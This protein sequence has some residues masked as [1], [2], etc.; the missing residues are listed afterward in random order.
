MNRAFA[1]ALLLLSSPVARGQA[2]V[3]TPTTNFSVGNALTSGLYGSIYN[4]NAIAGTYSVPNLLDPTMGF[5]TTQVG[6]Y[7]ANTS[8]GISYGTPNSADNQVL[9]TWLQGDGASVVYTAPHIVPVFDS[10]TNQG[11]LLYLTGYIT[12]TPAMLNT[13]LTYSLGLDDG[14][15]LTI[16]GTTVINNGGIHGAATV[17][18]QVI[19][20]RAGLYPITLGYYDGHATQA[21]FSAMFGGGGLISI[22]NGAPLVGLQLDPTANTIQ[23][24]LTNVLNTNPADPTFNAAV[25]SLANLSLGRVTSA[26]YGAAVKELSPAKY[27]ALNEQTLADVDFITNDLDDYLAHRRTDAGTFRPGNGID[28]GGMSVMG[29]SIDP[30]LQDIA[31]H[32][33]AYNGGNSSPKE[34]SDSPGPSMDTSDAAGLSQRWNIFSRGIVVLS[35]DFSAGDL[36]HTEATSG[37]LQIGADYQVSPNLLVGAFFEYARSSASLDEEGSDSSADSYLPGV[38]ASYAKNGWYANALGSGGVNRFDVTRNIDLP[39][40]SASANSHPNGEE[41]YG[42][43]SGGHDFHFKNLTFGPTAGVQYVHTRTDEFTESGAGGLDLDVNR[44]DSD[45]LRSR[46]GGRL[47]YAASLAGLTLRPFLDASWQHE[48]MENDNS[49]TAGFD[50]AGVGTFTVPTPANTRESAL[51]SVGTDIDIDANS[52]VFTVYRVEAG[53]S[54]FFAQSVEAGFKLA[55]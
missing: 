7:V 14:G 24:Y 40:F 13:P 25:N 9:T 48:F 37:T 3:I 20:T 30:A 17:T 5:G 50:G 19:F 32:L 49:L 41:E 42:Y 35:Q 15:L 45:S 53:S 54:N 6:S 23:N 10:G 39:G 22:P 28:L 26:E 31:G 47:Y 44:H 55:Y 4:F 38:Y 8:A 2:I 52:E 1:I 36:Q 43:V 34:M 27:G 51:V 46:L 21:V 16:N 11:T 18:Q 29:G 33:L 12:V